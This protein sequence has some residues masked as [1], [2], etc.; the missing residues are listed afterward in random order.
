MPPTE[1]TRILALL[2]ERVDIGTTGL[3]VQL[4]IDG[5]GGLEQDMQVHQTDGA[6]KRRRK[7]AL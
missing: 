2:V 3:N 1:K 5:L 7:L 4:R 6:A